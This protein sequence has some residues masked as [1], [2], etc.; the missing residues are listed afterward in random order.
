MR[1]WRTAAQDKCGGPGA[2][3]L[4]TGAVLDMFLIGRWG[5]ANRM[6]LIIESL[7]VDW[8]S[9]L[10]GYASES[11]AAERSRLNR[12]TRNRMHH[13]HHLHGSP[14]ARPAGPLLNLKTLKKPNV[15]IHTR[16]GNPNGCSL[17]P[18]PLESFSADSREIQR[19]MTIADPKD[20]PSYAA[21]AVAEFLSSPRT[22]PL[23]IDR[24][25]LTRQHRI[26]HL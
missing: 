3:D 25:K 10:G 14:L 13:L 7:M 6:T 22:E 5:G 12:L 19:A 16:G 1:Y 11:A 26:Q 18:L 24:P 9:P 17:P 23:S 15:T 21:A 2:E 4:V 20:I 8:K